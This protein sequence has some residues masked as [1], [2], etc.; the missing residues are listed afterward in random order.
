[1][2]A[3]KC[4]LTYN[5]HLVCILLLNIQDSVS[6]I[7][8]S[9]KLRNKD[10]HFECFGNNNNN[11]SNNN[12]K[13]S[14]LYM[15]VFDSS[16]RRAVVVCCVPV[17]V[18]TVTLTVIPT[19]WHQVRVLTYTQVVMERFT[20]PNCLH[21]VPTLVDVHRDLG[22]IWIKKKTSGSNKLWYVHCTLICRIPIFRIRMF[23]T[24]I[25]LITIFQIFRYFEIFF[26][27]FKTR[28]IRTVMVRNS[29][30]D[31]TIWINDI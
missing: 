23:R 22:F 8:F 13:H 26:T 11:N 15:S 4:L 10:I 20:L 16:W 6:W 29:S 3:R 19:Q 1:M 17:V 24:V 30:S 9:Y 27:Q 28:I 25:C 2:L 14:Y 31:V 12:T 21:R 5:V 7:Y 18:G